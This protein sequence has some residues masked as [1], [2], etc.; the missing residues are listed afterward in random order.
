M[1]KRLSLSGFSSSNHQATDFENLGPKSPDLDARGKAYEIL[2]S[3]IE[4][5]AL[6]AR[7][8][9]LRGKSDIADYFIIASATSAR[10]AQGIAENIRREMKAA[11][12][13]P[14]SISGLE[15]GSWIV[16]DFGDVIAHIFHDPVRH[17]YDLDELWRGAHLLPLEPKLAEQAER[18]RTG[19]FL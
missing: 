16:L 18:L 10:H 2:K 14:L 3:S 15:N 7:G 4:Q 5:K 1:G 6:D 11:G 17:F 13:V 12:E 19:M 9:D 8:L